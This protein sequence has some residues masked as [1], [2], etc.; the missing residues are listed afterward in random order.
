M[1]YGEMEKII[2]EYH[3]LRFLNKSTAC[4]KDNEPEHGKINKMAC[5]PSEDSNQPGHPPSIIK[6]SLCAHWAA[7][8]SSFLHVDSDDSSQTRRM[9]R[10]I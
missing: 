5:A 1:F 7:K 9:P 6:V 8:D 2:P 3:Q 4:A 10:L